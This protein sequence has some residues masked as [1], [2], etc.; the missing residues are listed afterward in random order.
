MNY[1][2]EVKRAY[3]ASFER[4]RRC[5]VV[6]SKGAEFLETHKEYARRNKYVEKSLNDV[7]GKRKVHEQMCRI[8]SVGAE[9]N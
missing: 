5:Y 4:K 9:G 8:G 7:D 6:T 3:L 2:G 1:L